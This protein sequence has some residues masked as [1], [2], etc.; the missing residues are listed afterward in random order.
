LDEFF[1]HFVSHSIS[2]DFASIPLISEAKRI[3]GK[4]RAELVTQADD[5]I[6]LTVKLAS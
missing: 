6:Q 1:L 3:T 5:S 4:D 2:F